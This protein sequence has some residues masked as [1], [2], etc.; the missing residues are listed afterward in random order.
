MVTGLSLMGAAT[1]LCAWEMGRPRQAALS[2]SPR[3]SSVALPSAATRVEPMPTVEATCPS[4]LL[5]QRVE[6]AEQQLRGL[7]VSVRWEYVTSPDHKAGTV[8]AVR[9]APGT[10]LAPGDQVTLQVA[11]APTTD[12]ARHA[13][14]RV[15]WTT[16]VGPDAPPDVAAK[17]LDELAAESVHCTYFVCGSWARQHPDLLRRMAGEGH[18]I[19]NHTFSHPNLTKVRLDDD[20]RAEIGQT[21]SVIVEAVGAEAM[22]LRKLFRPPFGEMDGRVTRIVAELG[23]KVVMW[24]VDPTDWDQSVTSAQITERI[25]RRTKA[26][27]IILTHVNA[28]T[29]KAMPS[30]FAGLRERQLSPA[31]VAELNGG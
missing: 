23:Y 13:P 10:P 19:G 17:M 21:Q 20:I 30:I 1:L 15:A 9:P 14:R 2:T 8:I 12:Q 26:G 25:L 31:P 5:F 27:S 28:R 18:Q 29:L 24:H 4:G 7:P 16:D 22:G 6:E 11:K 3:A